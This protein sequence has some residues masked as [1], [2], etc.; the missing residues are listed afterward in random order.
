MFT[1][2][3]VQSIS[4]QLL[5]LSTVQPV[6]AFSGDTDQEG[7]GFP[8]DDDFTTSAPSPSQ[9]IETTILPITSELE[10]EG[11]TRAPLTRLMMTTTEAGRE[12]ITTEPEGTTSSR[13][14]TM[15]TSTQESSTHSPTLST[16]SVESMATRPIPR[17]ASSTHLRTVETTITSESE[18][19]G[20]TRAPLTRPMMTTTE[21]GR[22]RIT[23]EPEATTSSR[24]VTM[25]TSTQESSTHSGATEIESTTPFVTTE[26]IT[27]NPPFVIDE[28]CRV[29]AYASIN[30]ETVF[31]S[32]VAND[33]LL[34][35][36]GQCYIACME[37]L[38]K[39]EVGYGVSVLG[40][41][42]ESN[43][44]ERS[45]SHTYSILKIVCT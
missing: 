28:E 23:T 35:V 4:L 44:F 1:M 18:T 40:T 45:C 19:E 25:E 3:L 33:S 37:S 36:E 17:T 10:T 26:A 30:Y 21:A 8:D 38:S 24:F 34:A 32:P 11:A 15:E 29:P 41:H 39:P 42:G 16:E 22:E 31:S 14:V 2:K 20:A 43:V 13:F 9:T 7:S 6:A 5:L 27:K 12:R